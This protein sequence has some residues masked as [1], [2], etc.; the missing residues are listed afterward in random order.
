MPELP[1]VETARLELVPAMVG[2]SFIDVELRRK[3]LRRPFVANFARRLRGA[4]VT[5]LTRRGKFMLAA[6]STGDTLVMHLGMSGSFQVDAVDMVA[7]RLRHD[8]VVFTMSSRH[9]VTYNDP[10]RF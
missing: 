4:S 10:R 8:H 3:D 1:E 9:R 6:L 7:D 5:S 2:A